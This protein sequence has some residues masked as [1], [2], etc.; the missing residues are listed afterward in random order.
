[1]YIYIYDTLHYTYNYKLIQFEVKKIQLLRVILV[2]Y[3]KIE[4]K[5]CIHFEIVF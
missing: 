3:K 2:Y 4:T 5:V 1:M